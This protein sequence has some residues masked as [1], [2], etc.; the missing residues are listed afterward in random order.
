MDI[1][2]DI[3]TFLLLLTSQNLFPE[4]RLSI[5]GYENT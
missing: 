1:H 2:V 5:K 3:L 4:V